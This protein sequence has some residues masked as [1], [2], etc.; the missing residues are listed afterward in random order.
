MKTKQITVGASFWEEIQKL[1]GKETPAPEAGF[2]RQD[3]ATMEIVKM[4]K[5]SK[6]AAYRIFTSAVKAGLYERK[7]FHIGTNANR[8]FPVVYYRKVGQG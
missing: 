4:T 5:V 2:V 6:R 3:E 7:T 1:K 8:R